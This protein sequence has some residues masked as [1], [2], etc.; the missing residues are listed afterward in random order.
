MK[1]SRSPAMLSREKF[2]PVYGTVN[3]NLDDWASQIIDHAAESQTALCLKLP[4]VSTALCADRASLL[5]RL[6]ALP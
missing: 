3:A 6:I 1:T 5:G 2:W 4:C